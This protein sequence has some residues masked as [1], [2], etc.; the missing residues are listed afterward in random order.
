MNT[1]QIAALSAVA[2]IAGIS[3]SA[4]SQTLDAEAA[5]TIV[6][7][8]AARATA[9]GQSHGIAVVDLGGHLVAALRMDGNGWGI[10]AFAEEK[11]RAAAAWGFPTAG[12]A[13][14][15]EETPG[16]AGAP[17]VVAV[18]GGVPIF[19]AEGRERIG[20]AGA[21]GEPPEDDA[22]CVIAGIAAAGLRSSRAEN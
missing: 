20:G 18:G 15:V 1:K 5:Q 9:R 8:C 7:S 3:T 2:T 6:Q 16:F 21:S 22:A 12:M 10:Q 14:A 4:Q 17:D 19:D 13:R 11:A